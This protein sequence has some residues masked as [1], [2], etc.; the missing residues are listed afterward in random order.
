MTIKKTIV[1]SYALRRLGMR[2]YRFVMVIVMEQSTGSQL[3][4]GPSPWDLPVHR[5]PWI[6]TADRRYLQFLIYRED[7]GDGVRGCLTPKWLLQ[8]VVLTLLS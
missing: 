4:R 8:K 3:G 2:S 5:G 1:V 7:A 6:G